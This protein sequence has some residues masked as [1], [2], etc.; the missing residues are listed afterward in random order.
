MFQN[1]TV[2]VGTVVSVD[3]SMGLVVV[4]RPRDNKLWPASFSFSYGVQGTQYNFLE[5]LIVG[6]DGQTYF[7]A[8]VSIFSVIAAIL[9]AAVIYG[10]YH[11]LHDRYSDEKDNKV[12]DISNFNESAPDTSKTRNQAQA[13]PRIGGKHPT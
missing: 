4:V 7:I 5:S 2:P 13:T 3:A 12:Y 8:G 11:C 9:V 10:V 1:Q 6:P